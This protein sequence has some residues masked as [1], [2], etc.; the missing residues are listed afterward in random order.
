MTCNMAVTKP[1]VFAPWHQKLGDMPAARPTIN[2]QMNARSPFLS[3][4]ERD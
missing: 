3:Y 1:P 2:V 4:M